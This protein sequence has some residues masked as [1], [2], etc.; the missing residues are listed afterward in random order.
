MAY[1]HYLLLIFVLGGPPGRIRSISPMIGLI[2]KGAHPMKARSRLFP[3]VLV[4]LMLVLAACGGQAAAPAATSAPVAAEP[5]SAP[6]ASAAT[7]AP[8]A[9]AAAEAPT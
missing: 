1:V 3:F 2:R 9:T 8:E 6:A 5:T 7:A 4:L